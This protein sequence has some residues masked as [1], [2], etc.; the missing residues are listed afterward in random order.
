VHNKAWFRGLTYALIASLCFASGFVLEK[1]SLNNVSIPT[2]FGIAWFFSAVIA[3]ALVIIF[4]RHTLK[5]LKDPEITTMAIRLGVIRAIAGALFVF[6]LVKSNNVTLMSVISNFRIILVTILAGILL[7]ERDH[8][9]QKLAAA[10]VAFVA[11]G[12]IFWN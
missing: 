11:L 12:I 2:Y 3:W 10:A 9:T 1:Y 7:N 6:A 5:I 8:Y 4:R